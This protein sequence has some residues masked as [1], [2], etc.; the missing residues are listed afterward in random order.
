MP[1]HLNGQPREDLHTI[2]EA[3][4]A[5]TTATKGVAVAVNSEVV[6]KS[7]WGQELNDGDKVEILTATQGG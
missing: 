6:P 1:I 2:A 7:Q 3:V 5:I 4:A